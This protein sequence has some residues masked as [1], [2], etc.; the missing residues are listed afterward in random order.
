MIAPPRID[1]IF[2]IDDEWAIELE[3]EVERWLDELPPKRFGAA[4]FHIDRLATLGSAL[5]PPVSRSLGEG[6][7]ELRFDLDRQ[8]FRLTYYFA[9]GRR[10]VLLTA[11]RKQRMNERHEVNRARDAMAKCIR[12][13]HTAEED[14]E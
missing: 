7:Y 8:A 13:G 14:D 9:A 6:L 12:E 11:F 5:R 1:I 2:D 4:A 10:I 3:P